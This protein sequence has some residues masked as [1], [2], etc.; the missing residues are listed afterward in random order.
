MAWQGEPAM[1][2]LTDPTKG[3][4]VSGL[5]VDHAVIVHWDPT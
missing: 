2:R 4:L 5:L 3:A 1:A